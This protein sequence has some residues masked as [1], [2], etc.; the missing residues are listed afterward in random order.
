MKKIMFVA[1]ACG[2][3]AI[4][5]AKG[6]EPDAAPAAASPAASAADVEALRQQVQSLTELVQTLQ[7]QVKEQ[8]IANEKNNSNPPALPQNPEPET[9]TAES[10]SPTESLAGSPIRLRPRLVNIQRPATQIGPIQ[11][12]NRPLRLTLIRHLHKRKAPR[13]SGLP[14]GHDADP[15]YR[16]IS[17]KEGSYRLFANTKI[18]VAYKNVFQVFSLA[19]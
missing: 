12:R 15:F 3:L 4:D 19:I 5:A 18:E 6:A 2:A 11:R 1:L 17:F 10:A 14:V 8:Q 13:P 16:A 9:A 7:K